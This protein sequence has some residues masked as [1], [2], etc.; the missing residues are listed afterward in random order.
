M[1]NCAR[2]K[3]PISRSWSRR[4]D[5]KKMRVSFAR[6]DQIESFRKLRQGEPVV[7]DRGPA[8]IARFI[9]RLA[10][11]RP[12]DAPVPRVHESPAVTVRV[13]LEILHVQFRN[14]WT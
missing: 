11:C 14:E 13:E 10:H 12:I 7:L 2:S 9:Q 1:K 6:F 3:G 5:R 8:V 4:N